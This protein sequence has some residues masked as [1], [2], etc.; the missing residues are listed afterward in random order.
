MRFTGG[1]GE[2]LSVFA[3]MVNMESSR[4]VGHDAALV[5]ADA[6][7]STAQSMLST[8]YH[9]AAYSYAGTTQL[10]VRFLQSEDVPAGRRLMVSQG[11]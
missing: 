3:N 11:R 10:L 2:N 8:D 5:D 7:Y 1:T 9:L 6:A 4:R